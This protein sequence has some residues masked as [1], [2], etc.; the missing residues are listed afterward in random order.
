MATI[1]TR[2]VDGEIP[3]YKIA[4]TDQFL[5]FLDARPTVEGHTLCIIKREVDYYFDLTDDELAGLTLFSKRVAHALKQVID[6]K[7]IAVAV[8]GLEVPHAHVHLIPVRTER[9]FRLGSSIEVAPERMEKIAA[10][11]RAALEVRPH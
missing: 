11:V 2:I 7:R 5:S 9:D 6:C 4:E 10:A 1:F 3:C 8:L